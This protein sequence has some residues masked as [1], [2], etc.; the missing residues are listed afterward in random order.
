M[1][2]KAALQ[3]GIPALLA[4]IGWNA[5]L[6]VNHLNRVQTIAALTLESSAIQAELSGVL[7]DMTDMETSQR[8]YLLTGNPAYLQPYTETKGRIGTDFASLRTGL[9]SRTQREQSLE[10][11]LEVLARSKQAEI[12]RSISLRQQGYRRRSFM[13]VDTNEGKDYMDEIRRIVS[14]LSAAESGNYARF[15]SERIAALKHA[16]SL[17]LVSNSV[18]LVLAAGL[19]GLVRQHLRL[20]AEEGS[21]SRIELAVRDLQLEK[22]TSALSGQARSNLVAMNTNSRLLLENYGDFLP[23]QGHEYAEQMNEA[24]AQMERLRQ[25]LVGRQVSASDENAA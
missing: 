1:I 23:R 17:T 2:R 6:A 13:L 3:I 14:S 24:A 5:Y 15:D 16:L 12:E 10:S 7:K 11:R 22:L 19:F 4:F 25:D 21:Q 20:L 9:A 8:G 18:L